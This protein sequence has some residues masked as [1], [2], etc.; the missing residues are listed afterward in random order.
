MN[1]V[2]WIGTA[3]ICVNGACCYTFMALNH[4]QQ[5]T[6]TTMFAQVTIYLPYWV[7]VRKRQVMFLMSFEPLTAPYVYGKDYYC[8]PIFILLRVHFILVWMMIIPYQLIQCPSPQLHKP[9]REHCQE[10]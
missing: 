6:A 9:P 10:H 3:L 5:H 4:G 2:C 8:H 7:I 1:M